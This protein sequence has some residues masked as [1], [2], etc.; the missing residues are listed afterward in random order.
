MNPGSLPDRIVA[1]LQAAI[2]HPD[3][4]GTRYRLIREIGRGGMGVVY[5]VEDTALQRRLALKVM[6]EDIGEGRLIAQLEHP[7]IVPV[8]DA[9]TLPDGR[10]FYTMRLIRG[11]RMD[12]WIQGNPS[13]HARMDVFLRVCE[14]VSFAHSR[15]VVHRD[16]KPA[17]VMIGDWGEVLVLDW[18]MGGTKGFTPPEGAGSPRGDVYSLGRVLQHLGKDGLPGPVSSICRKATFPDPAGRYGNAAELAADLGLFLNGERVSAHP[19]NAVERGQRLA[20]R[21]RALLALVA[22]YLLMRVALLVVY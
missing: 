8:H 1:G 3:L 4:S 6:D 17:N 11:K 12:E 19:E 21:H 10:V 20:R 7:G 2:T 14:A 13:F 15:G 5:E 18:G 9:G 22:A 16:L